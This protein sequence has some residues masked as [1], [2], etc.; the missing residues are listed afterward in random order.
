MTINGGTGSPITNTTPAIAELATR[1]TP[2]LTTNK[3]TRVTQLQ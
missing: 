1:K 3:T 2:T